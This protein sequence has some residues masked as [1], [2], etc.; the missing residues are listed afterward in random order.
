MEKAV[1][2]STEDDLAA[3]SHI[4]FVRWS[5]GRDY[6]LMP[7]LPSWDEVVLKEAAPEPLPRRPW[8]ERLEKHLAGRA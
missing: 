6:R 3:Q 5:D 8:R 1:G 4:W 2:F 7:P